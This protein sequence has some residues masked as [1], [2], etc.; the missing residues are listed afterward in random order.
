[1]LLAI[2]LTSAED[3]NLSA[4]VNVIDTDGALT[5]TEG[6]R[7]YGFV[8]PSHRRRGV[9]RLAHKRQRTAQAAI[10]L[11]RDPEGIMQG[12]RPGGTGVSSLF[13][14]ASFY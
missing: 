2:L 7:I 6:S 4:H 11:R 10:S 13:P 5:P 12:V 3:Y 1:M 9:R 8:P 14:S